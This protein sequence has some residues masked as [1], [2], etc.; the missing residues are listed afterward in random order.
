MFCRDMV[1]LLK[2]EID[3]DEEEARSKEGLPS[4]AM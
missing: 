1:M 3:V 4:M 2:R